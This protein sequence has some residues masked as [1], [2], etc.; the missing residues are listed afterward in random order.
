[1]NARCP[2][3]SSV[4]VQN[5][6]THTTPPASRESGYLQRQADWPNLAN[7]EEMVEKNRKTVQVK[8]LVFEMRP[9][10]FERPTFGFGVQ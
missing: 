7:I 5:A 1:V 2:R 10:R 6:M 3:N 9:R 4:D 8:L